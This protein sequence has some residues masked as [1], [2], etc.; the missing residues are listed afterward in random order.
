MICDIRMLGA[1]TAKPLTF[2][3][4]YDLF[5]VFFLRKCVSEKLLSGERC[6]EVADCSVQGHAEIDG[7]ELDQT[8]LLPPFS[9]S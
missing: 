7:L 5:L 3:L 9:I 2:R 1:P 6:S 8:V 4:V